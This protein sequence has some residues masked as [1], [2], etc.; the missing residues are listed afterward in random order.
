M[1]A[2]VLSSPGVIELQDL[3]DPECPK[4]GALI[5]VVACSVC[6]TDIKMIENG[7]RDL[8]Y[9]RIPGHEIVGRVVETKADSC[10]EEGDMIQVWP[11]IA[12]GR[13]W[14]CMQAHDHRCQKIKI[15][16]FNCDGG[17]AE[18]LA[19]PHESILGGVNALPPKI[20]PGSI[21]LAEPLACCLNAQEQ[22]DVSKGDAVLI[23]GAGPT[24]CLH[25]LLA[26]L[27][28]AEKVIM[29]EKLED[30]ILKL[31]KHV[32]ALALNCRESLERV[33]AEETEGKGV[34]VILTATPDVRVDSSLLRLLNS[35]GRICL[36]SG[37]LPDNYAV[38][39]DIRQL[40]YREL[41]ISGAYG[42][43]SRQNREAV[44]LLVTG[45]IE[46]DWIITK[47]T[48]LENINEA[49]SHSSQ[50]LGLKSVICRSRC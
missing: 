42:C 49:L 17:F 19:I 36:F 32:D 14:H 1:K 28:G 26:K 4:D 11:G 13:C 15:L 39:M 21:A 43:S 18:L 30:R 50:R 46:A 6:G 44:N 2:A 9:P 25:A 3:L 7:H 12:C 37:P 24:G 41:K 22:V 48:S 29:I 33:I 20:D 8:I 34:D 16:G 38:R 10:L 40:H 35:G 5:E 45:E 47:R 27:R 31:E 23:F